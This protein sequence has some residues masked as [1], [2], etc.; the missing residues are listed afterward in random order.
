MGAASFLL[1]FP[2][3]VIHGSVSITH[4]HAHQREDGVCFLE[5]KIGEITNRGIRD[6][7][8]CRLW[9]RFWQKDTMLRAPL[10]QWTQH[11]AVEGAVIASLIMFAQVCL[12][13]VQCLQMKRGKRKG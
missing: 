1:L 6:E 2:E 5:H 9:G 12:M 7:T 8:H 11:S 10:S 13:C 4:L 3:E